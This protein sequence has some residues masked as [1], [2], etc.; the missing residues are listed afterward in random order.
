M[1]KILKSKPSEIVILRDQL[2]QKT[3][4]RKNWNLNYLL[5]E[6]NLHF[7]LRKGKNEQMN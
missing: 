2:A 1:A 7:S 5:P 3:K 6:E 4:K